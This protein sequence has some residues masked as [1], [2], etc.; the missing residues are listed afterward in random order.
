MS[1]RFHPHTYLHSLCREITVE[2]LRFLAVLQSPLLQFPSFGIHKSNLLEAR[3]II[4]SYND[5]CSAP[6]SRALLVG[7][8]P[9]KF[10]RV[11]EP[12]LSWNQLHNVA[13]FV[14]PAPIT[15]KTLLR[16]DS[17]D[18]IRQPGVQGQVL[19][20]TDQ[21]IVSPSLISHRS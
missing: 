17:S 8:Y 10:R 16:L 18:P 1:A 14:R 7:W 11:Q 13:P 2:L 4:A 9:P 19:A 21:W 5:H 20:I 3:V 6:L 15:L 12:T